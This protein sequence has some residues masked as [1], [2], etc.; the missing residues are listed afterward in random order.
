MTSANLNPVSQPTTASVFESNA[1]PADAIPPQPDLN[2]I[3]QRLESSNSGTRMVALASLRHIPAIDAFPFIKKALEDENLQIRSMAVFALGIKPTEESYPI[4][5][6][7]LDCLLYT[8]P[9]PRD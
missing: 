5:V 9:S 1:S 6:K 8:S 3:A 7:L 4:L 2:Q